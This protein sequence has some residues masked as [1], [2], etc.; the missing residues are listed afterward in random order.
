MLVKSLSSAPEWMM[1]I[2]SAMTER[3]P[4][5][6]DSLREAYGNF[7]HTLI[8]SLYCDLWASYNIIVIPGTRNL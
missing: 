4:K 2:T 6:V 3:N 1:S 7:R 8:H 5:A